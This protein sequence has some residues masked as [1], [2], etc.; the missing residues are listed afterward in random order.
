M[1]FGKNKT[2]AAAIALILLFVVSAPI[3]V[4][5]AQFQAITN[6]PLVV[7][8]PTFMFVSASPNPVGVGQLVYLGAVFSRPTP[9]D[10]GNG[11]DFYDNVTIDVID[12][13]G[14]KTVF[15][16]WITSK[17]AGIQFSYTPEKVGNYT[18]QA[19]YPGQ[20]LIGDHRGSSSPA[21]SGWNLWLL[22]ST[23]LPSDS[24]ILTLVVQAEPVTATYQTPPLPTEFWTRPIYGTNTNWGTLGANWFG[25]GGSGAYDAAENVQPFGTAPNTAHIMWTKPT[26]FGGQPG[27]PINATER[28]EYSSTSLLKVYFKPVCILNGILYYNKYDGSPSSNLLGW[29]ALDLHTGEVLWDKPAGVTGKESI[30]WG[31]IVNYVN[32]QEIGSNAFLYSQSGGG[33]FGT[34]G[35]NWMG[36]YDAYTGNYLANVTNT[37]STSRIIDYQADL[38]GAVVGY[39]VSGN[40]L[41]MYNYTK[42]L[43]AA[44]G[45]TPETFIS[46]SGTINGSAP[47]CTE[48]SVPLP[49]TFNGDSISLSIA[50]VTSDII[51]MRQVPSAFQWEGTNLG[52]SYDAGYDARTGAKLW[53]P[54]NQTGIWPSYED[55]SLLCCQ[56]DYYVLRNKDR[57]QLY[58]FDLKTGKKLW[59]PTQL[60]HGSYSSVFIQGI[61]AY[62]RV[63]TSDLGGYVNAVNLTTGKVE[64]TFTRGSSGYDTSFGCYPIFGYNTQSV[65]DGKLFLTEGI[66]YTIPLYPAKRL[67]INCTDGSLV[68]SVSQYACTCVGAVGDGYLVSWN[69]LDN[70]IYCFGKGSTATTVAAS[71]A[72]QVD[73]DSVIITGTVMDTSAGTNET[74]CTTRFPN[75]VP[76]V[77]DDSQEAWMEYVYQQQIRPANATG[78]EVTLDAIDPNNNFVHIGNVTSDTSGAFGYAWK[79]PDVTGKYTIIATFAG[80]ESYYA[81]FAETYAVVSE[82]PTAT[83]TPTYPVPPDT[84]WTIIGMGIA[85]II[86]VIIVGILLLL[87]KKP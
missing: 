44:G 47:R 32:Y 14:I 77:S 54:I 60:V 19:H 7:D 34:T 82:A 33:G 86:V 70:Q 20:K 27:S 69:S 16:P 50:G 67:A 22:N 49:T 45:M 55:V 23:M 52:Y 12:P 46:A 57:L 71:P 18:I 79:T 48:W 64:W 39:Y 3:T 73:G 78:V 66:M 58:G 81:S 11:G 17:A 29:E 87:R 59:G 72:V 68:W 25:L 43:T 80:S 62:G 2:K 8:I 37:I 13:N 15:G 26:Q 1:N 75:G 4:T 38:G 35:G 9:T 76:A 36:I 63:Y 65:A 56:D 42:L 10:N 61:I 41:C 51:L 83:P 53:G 40:N 28:S 5:S 24:D 85:I 30:I 6:P 84:T 21:P 31:Q 74:V